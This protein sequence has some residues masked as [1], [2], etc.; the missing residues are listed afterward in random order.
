MNHHIYEM[1]SVYI[2]CLRASDGNVYRIR[3]KIYKDK[4]EAVELIRKL[5]ASANSKNYIVMESRYWEELEE[6]GE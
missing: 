6:V 1:G 5:N 2:I 4:A 3:R